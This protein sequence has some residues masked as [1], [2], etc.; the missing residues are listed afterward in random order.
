M[1]NQFQAVPTYRKVVRVE[2]PEGLPAHSQSSLPDYPWPVCRRGQGESA[3]VSLSP[4]FGDHSL[5]SK[6]NLV[7]FSNRVIVCSLGSGKEEEVA[8]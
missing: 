1:F 8:I 3:T 4:R 6:Q 2:T 5:V 7:I